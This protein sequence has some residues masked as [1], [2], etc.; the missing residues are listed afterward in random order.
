MQP[1][2]PS[3]HPL[4]FSKMVRF[5]DFSTFYKSLEDSGAYRTV[6][7]SHISKLHSSTGY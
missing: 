1:S 7:N 3:E 5:S 2:N 6:K 4:L